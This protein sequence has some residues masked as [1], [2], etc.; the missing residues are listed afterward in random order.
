M[1]KTRRHATKARRRA[2]KNGFVVLQ[3]EDVMVR[4]TYTGYNPMDGITSVF[5]ET[6]TAEGCAVHL[7]DVHLRKMK[8]WERC[9][10]AQ[11]KEALIDKMHRR[12]VETVLRGRRFT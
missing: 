11:Y 7:W 4:A 2:F 9:H 1:S 6:F 12:A 8:A 10:P 5:V 3:E